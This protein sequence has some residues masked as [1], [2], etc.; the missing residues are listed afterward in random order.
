V[1]ISSAL[2]PKVFF[3]EIALV[4][5]ALLF[6]QAMAVGQT[7]SGDQAVKSSVARPALQE[8]F[9]ER[10]GWLYRPV[11]AKLELARMLP[12]LH[13]PPEKLRVP[14][15]TNDDISFRLLIK[16]TS[17]EGKTIILG[18]AYR[19]DRPALYK[20]GVLMP[21]RKDALDKIEA[22]D[23]PGSDF[24]RLRKISPGEEFTEIIKLGDWYEPLQ[25][26]HYELKVCRRFIWGGDWIETPPLAFGV[27]P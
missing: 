11:F 15:R 14:F 10:Y 8:E 12:E 23:S 5:I 17:A 1:F 13:D 18:S 16:N 22:T 2:N 7:C 27:A 9:R 4:A 24:E 21:Y 26:G 3:G 19:Y 25:P 6:L 20:D